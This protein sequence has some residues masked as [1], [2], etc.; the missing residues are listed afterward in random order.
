MTSGNQRQWM[1]SS[2]KRILIPEIMRLGYDS[3]PLS[4][5][6]KND[7]ECT[8]A[9]PFGKYGKIFGGDMLQVEPEIVRPFGV[10]ELRV[11]FARFPNHPFIL[12]GPLGEALIQPQDVWS[13]FITDQ[14][15]ALF[16]KP[17]RMKPFGLSWWARRSATQ[18]DYDELVL[19]VSSNLYQLEDALMFE[20]LGPNVHK[21]KY[22]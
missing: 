10:P 2:I 20:R 16:R 22:G 8:S 13:S 1:R 4:I 21:Y 12:T 3:L 11:S 9:F 18:N 15:Y 7:R 14:S 17:S 5:E 6:D 19:Y